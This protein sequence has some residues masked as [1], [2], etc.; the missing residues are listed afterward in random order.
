MSAADFRSGFA[1]NLTVA[2]SVAAYGSVL[3][4]LASQQG[5]SLVQLV[6]MNLIL[7][8]GSSQF[9]L[10]EMWRPP[11]P[12]FE[13]VLAVAVINLRYMLIGASLRP[14]FQNS[15][16]G[17]RMGFV[18]LAADENWAITMAA[19]RK[20]PVGP[21]HLLGGG[22]CLALSW[23]LGTIGGLLFGAA[24]SKPEAF[25]LDFAFLAVFIA[26]AASLWR[27]RRDILPWLIAAGLALASEALIPGKWYIIIGGLGGALAAMAIPGP[28]DREASH[29]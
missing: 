19:R 4:V 25:A 1:A 24:I 15:S 7:F 13:M 27:G 9:V 22:V 23:G 3:G 18:H 2:A 28:R 14:L 20:G 11:L 26:L 21:Y 29:A 8:A 10:I 6:V 5:L 12:V 17:Q 16:L